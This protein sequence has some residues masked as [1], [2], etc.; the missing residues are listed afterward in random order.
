MYSARQVERE[1][2]REKES[3][4]SGASFVLQIQ[5]LR[6]IQ[7]SQL[8]ERSREGERS[9]RMQAAKW[10]KCSVFIVDIHGD[11]RSTCNG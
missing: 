5:L 4:M 6:P 2:E 9:L 11:A 8:M 7:V 3:S 10:M 1:R